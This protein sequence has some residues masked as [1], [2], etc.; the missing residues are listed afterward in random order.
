M[1]LV[2]TG[3]DDTVDAAVVDIIGT[4]KR[5]AAIDRYLVA[6]VRK[7]RADLLGK[8]FKAAIAIGNAAGSDDGDLHGRQWP[9]VS[10]Q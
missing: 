1:L 5:A 9:V 3:N 6:M 2:E 4:G 10:G 8:T 7:A